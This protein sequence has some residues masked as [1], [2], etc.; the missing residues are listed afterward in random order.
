MLIYWKAVSYIRPQIRAQAVPSL[1]GGASVRIIYSD[2]RKYYA[3]VQL[4]C[5]DDEMGCCG[6][7]SGMYYYVQSWAVGASILIAITYHFLAGQDDFDRDLLKAHNVYRA[8][9]GSPPLSWSSQAARPARSWA[10]RLAGMGRLEH[11]NHTGTC[12]HCMQW[13]NWIAQ[14]V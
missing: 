9:H 13:I 7:K 12:T 8:K 3:Q 4:H 2:L 14:L 6:S 1:L 11:G 10:G 5:E